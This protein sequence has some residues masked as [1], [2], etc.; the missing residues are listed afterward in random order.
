MKQPIL[1]KLKMRGIYKSLLSMIG[2]LFVFVCVVGV[3]YL[4]YLEF[5]DGNSDIEV[6]GALSINYT[7]GKKFIIEDNKTIGFSI[8]NSSEDVR[9]YSIG[10]KSVRGTGEYKLYYK[11]VVILEG[12]LK[13][14]DYSKEEYISIDAKETKDYILEIKNTGNE[15]LSGTI[16]INTQGTKVITFADSILSNNQPSNDALTQ[17]GIEAATENEGLIKSSDDIGVS[18]YFRGN[19]SN[20]YVSFGDMLWRIVRING[21]GTVRLVLNDMADTLSNYYTDYKDNISY[22]DSNINT[23]LTSWLEVNLKNEMDYLANTKFCA[24][25]NHDSANNYASFTRIM[26]N[27]IPTL[28]CLGTS[29]N[30][31][32]GTLTIDEIIL[33]GASPTD[34]NKKYYLY[35]DKVNDVWYTMSGAKGDKS[36]MNMFMIDGNGKLKYDVNA[37]FYRKVRPVIN[38]VKNTEV[39][40]NGTL[41]NPYQIK[42]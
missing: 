2:F 40:G 25:I 11:N 24:D 30:S 28:N 41:D 36:S 29:F 26:T 8:S 4:S 5:A 31:N 19:V 15:P 7:N 32:I 1:V 9:Y 18:Y 22:K 42:E 38:L 16:N 10:F 37:N 35:N 33:A 27:K 23:Y 20:N 13:N 12:D 21:D 3:F 39:T 17:V 14:T 6:N 34:S